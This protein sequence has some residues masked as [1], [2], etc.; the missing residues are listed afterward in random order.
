[1]LLFRTTIDDFLYV[2]DCLF[3]F[4]IVGKIIG[5]SLHRMCESK[6]SHS[7]STRMAQ[8]RG[9]IECMNLVRILPL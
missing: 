6:Y 1:M 2:I 4:T 7:D 8:H 3:V 9:G 5:Q